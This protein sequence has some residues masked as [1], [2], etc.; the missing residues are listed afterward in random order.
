MTVGQVQREIH[1]GMTNA[2]VAA[3]LGSPNMV[4]TE[5]GSARGLGL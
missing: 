3:V 1:I 5:R 4:T 2:D